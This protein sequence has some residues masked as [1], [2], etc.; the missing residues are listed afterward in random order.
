MISKLLFGKKIKMLEKS[1]N[2][3]FIPQSFTKHNKY[4]RIF[5]PNDFDF[6]ISDEA[7]R[8]LGLRSRNVFEYFVGFKLAQ[9]LEI[10]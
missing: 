7:H 9:P 10:F 5:Q 6:V 2:C 8:S 1:R 4:K 3:N